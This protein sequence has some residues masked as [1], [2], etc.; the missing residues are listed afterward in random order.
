MEALGAGWIDGGWADVTLRRP[1]YAGELV[2]ITVG[3]SPSATG[4]SNPA[5]TLTVAAAVG[6]RV[7]LDGTVGLGSA[8]WAGDIRSPQS[9]PALG[10]PEVRP[11]YTIDDARLTSRMALNVGGAARGSTWR[12]RVR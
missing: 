7:V 4:D 12:V 8:R 3:P 10:P 9:S 6:E 5:R 1:L 11:T 2:R